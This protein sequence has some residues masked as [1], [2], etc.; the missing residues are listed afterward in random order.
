MSEVRILKNFINGTFVDA[1]T[2]TWIDVTSPATGKTI[3]KCPVSGKPDVEAAVAAAK[4]AFPAWSSR[5]VKDR[6]QI[7]IRFHQ[8][9]REHASELADLIVLEHGK[10]KTEV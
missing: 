1:T 2:T 5:T 4:S 8:L 6:C 9:M 7:L 10:T 3:A